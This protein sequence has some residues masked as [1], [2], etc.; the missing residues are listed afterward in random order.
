[1]WSDTLLAAER[2]HLIRIAIW[3]FTS[4]AAGTAFVT[5]I[6]VRRVNAP[7]VLWFAIQTL[8]WGS[9]EL[10]VTAARWSV[11]SMRDVSGATRLDRLTWFAI[12][13]D[14]GIIGAGMTAALLAWRFTRNLRAFGGGLGVVV[15]GLGL[16]VLD[17]TFASI[18][19]RLM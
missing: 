6:A 7:I 15:Q 9:L 8:V 5:V 12:G 18:L 4:A 2:S 19:A 10:I 1:M 3:A 17:L 14:V 16:L 13:V 11:L